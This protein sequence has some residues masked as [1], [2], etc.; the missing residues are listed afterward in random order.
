MSGHSKWS[1]IK[2]QKEA[3]DISRGKLYS[4]LSR[5]ISIAVKTGGGSD[6]ATN[7]KLRVAV[8]AAKSA[9]MPKSNIERAINKASAMGNLEELTYEGFGP[10]GINIIVEVATDNRNR[11]GQDLKGLFERA[12]GRLAGPGAVM[13]NFDSKGMVLIKKNTKAEE[14]MLSLIDL[15]VEDVEETD[16]GIEV[17]TNPENLSSTESKLREN[18]YKIISMDLVR[19]P[20]NL[21]L[22]DN[23]KT[24]DKTL[25]LLGSLS[26]LDD[27][28][29]VFSNF[30]LEDT[31]SEKV[32]KE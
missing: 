32:L 17:Y 3:K 20:I 8:D 29:K 23:V 14:Q 5:A 27:V 12:G 9:N 7:N 13:F 28:Q 25:K 2:R 19:K 30:D 22:V 16:D 6:P 26:K 31:I 1:T 4:K 24:A 15:G 11:T 18:D 10:E 21:Q